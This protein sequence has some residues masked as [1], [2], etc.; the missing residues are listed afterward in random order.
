MAYGINNETVAVDATISLLR[1]TF[2]ENCVFEH[3]VVGLVLHPDE[4][5]VAATPDS[6]CKYMQ[7]FLYVVDVCLCMCPHGGTYVI[8]IFA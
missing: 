5:Q 6:I 1:A 4:A 3:S 7:F 8:F 2:G